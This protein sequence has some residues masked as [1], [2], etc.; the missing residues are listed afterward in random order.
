MGESQSPIKYDRGF[1]SK[2]GFCQNN[3]PRKLSYPKQKKIPNDEVPGKSHTTLYGIFQEVHGR[4]LVFRWDDSVFDAHHFGKNQFLIESHDRILIGDC[5][6]PISYHRAVYGIFQEVHGRNLVFQKDNSVF[7]V[8][9]FGQT[10][11][12]IGRRNRI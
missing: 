6:S 1:Q 8:D 2:I 11:F 7:C 4:N 3:V 5:D 9:H 10:R 12:S